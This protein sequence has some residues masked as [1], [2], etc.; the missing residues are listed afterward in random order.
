M[1]NLYVVEDL[2][3]TQSWGDR[4]SKRVVVSSRGD[5]SNQSVMSV[6]GQNPVDKSRNNNDSKDTYKNCN[7]RFFFNINFKFN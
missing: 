2:T 5:W 3:R 1:K 6:T 4:S 7:L